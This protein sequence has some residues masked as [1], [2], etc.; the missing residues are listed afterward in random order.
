MIIY[1]T[2]VMF[3]KCLISS[4]FLFWMVRNVKLDLMLNQKM[5]TLSILKTHEYFSKG[6]FNCFKYHAHNGLHP[7]LSYF[8]FKFFAYFSF[9]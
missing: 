7:F 6:S 9:T 1:T 8:N 2:Q 4:F 5:A 3:L